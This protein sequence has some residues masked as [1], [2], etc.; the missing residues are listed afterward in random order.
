MATANKASAA[1]A[2]MVPERRALQ[3]GSRLRSAELLANAVARCR[4]ISFAKEH[5]GR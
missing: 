2:V 1:A 5:L 4:R 3:E